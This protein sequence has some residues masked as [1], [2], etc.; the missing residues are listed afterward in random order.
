[1][2]FAPGQQVT[3]TIRLV[4]LL[5]KGGMG[6]VWAARHSGL[7]LDVAVK[8]ISSELAKNDDP[9][10]TERFKREAQLAARIDSPNVVR[11]FD[12]GM[13]PEGV[14]YIVME[15]LRG[16]SLYERLQSRRRLPPE[17]A[18]RIVT[19]VA[20]GLERAHALGIVHRDIKPHNVFL[21]K[22]PPS[23]SRAPSDEEAEE[24]VKLLDFG[25]AKA[26]TNE[27]QSLS[28]SSGVLIGTP[29]YMSPEQLMRAGP[30]EPSADLWA[31]SVLAY[32]MVTGK[33]PFRGETLAATLVAITRADVEPP[34]SLS[35]GIP[36]ALD[37][38]F[39]QALATDP[40]RRFKTARDLAAA[41][42]EAVTGVA[43]MPSGETRISSSRS[44]SRDASTLEQ[45]KVSAD[46]P[47]SEGTTEFL[48]MRGL[49]VPAS[50]RP[51]NLALAATQLDVK[52]PPKP[53]HA[54]LRS[55]TAGDLPPVEASRPDVKIEDGPETRFQRTWT[56]RRVSVVGAAVLVAGLS[57]GALIARMATRT[58]PLPPPTAVASEAV[59]TVDPS[60]SATDSAP[61]ASASAGPQTPTLGTV[62]KTTIAAGYV[63]L[64]RVWLPEYALSREDGDQDRALTD[65]EAA[66]GAKAMALCTESQWARACEA[67]PE[68]ASLASWTSSTTDKGAVVRGGSTGSPGSAPYGFGGT[69]QCTN[70]DVVAP[71]SHDPHR[72]GVCC[73]RVVG[74]SSKIDAL[75]FLE[76]TSKKLLDFEVSLNAGD[77]HG[78]AMQVDDP[79]LFY[80]RKLSRDDVANYINWRAREG[81][82]LVHDDCEVQMEKHDGEDAQWTA[83]CS[84]TSFAPGRLVRL[85]RRYVRGGPKGLL[86]EVREPRAPEILLPKGGD[87]PK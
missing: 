29:Q 84:A 87:P 82:F 13:T 11:T 60:P 59:P 3:A 44:R 66:C 4:S 53:D 16:E 62:P 22:A 5:G 49:D 77:G 68:I 32:E 86:L 8:F 26:R 2:T 80:A 30:V 50:S 28:T 31:L 6:S 70:R 40:D 72:I 12:H 9:L 34:S 41:L 39:G 57:G 81:G 71:D 56:R 38:W 42:E 21:S 55:A 64:S 35:D 75:A 45:S 18:S 43:P 23:S 51:S 76:T 10:V 67:H 54:T 73:S 15:L 19:E 79:T 63:P 58:P 20:R 74:V 36:A 27:A 48:A 33:L 85:S 83:D 46:T 14:P 7:D 24:V 37:E 17:E 78:V 69:A 47:A 61:V 25:V 52:T 1:M 65:A